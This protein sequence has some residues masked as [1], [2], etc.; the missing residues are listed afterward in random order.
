VAD[1][2]GTVRASSWAELFD[3]PSRWY[4]K[5]VFGLQSPPS[6]HST[7]GTAIHAGTAV[8]DQARLDG[9][10][11]D[12]EL[13]TDIA[14][15]HVAEMEDVD[16]SEISQKDATSIAVRLVANYC[17]V[18]APKRTYLAVEVSCGQLDIATQ[19]GL[20]RVTGTADRI[21]EDEDGRLG[22]CDLKSG[23]SATTE[24]EAGERVAVTQGHNIQ[25]GIYTLMAE[26]ESGLT[27]DAPAEIIGLQTTKDAHVASGYI[28]DVK[29]PLLGTDD[30]PGLIEI[31]A[32][33]LKSGV[34]PPNPKSTLCSP[35]F[36]PAYVG[37]CIYHA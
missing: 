25:L 28:V 29:T 10:E 22:V 6:S 19:H 23:K 5:H 31:A 2:L 15:D 9:Y 7:I 8:F 27:L 13:A 20:I 30:A 11:G 32:A 17:A 21:R 33:M 4:W 12:R 14:K 16:W 1:I 36:C 3:C 37:R 26:Q 34:F 35:K 24:D 18:I